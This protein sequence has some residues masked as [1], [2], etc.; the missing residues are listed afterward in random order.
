M[1]TR[2]TLCTLLVALIGLAGPGCDI[3]NQGADQEEEEQDTGDEESDEE[4]SEDEQ[5][6][7]EEAS[8]KEEGPDAGEEDAGDGKLS[9][10]DYVETSVK[11]ACVE[12][13][14]GEEDKIDLDEVEKEILG[15][16]GFDQDSY[17]DAEERFNGVDEVDTKIEKGMED[18]T[19]EKAKKYAGLIEDDSEEQEE[20]EQQEEQKE[21]PT[22]NSTGSFKGRIANQSGFDTAII[23]VTVSKDWSINGSLRGKRDGDSFRVSFDGTVNKSNRINASGSKGGDSV[24]VSG[25]VEEHGVDAKVRGSIAGDSFSASIR[26]N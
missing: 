14:L 26:A 13:E 11:L 9:L 16:Y 10:E 1:K 19:P 6:E 23:Q 17:D 8:D 20:T 15:E 25:T 3:L 7:D 12:S 5:E 21:P 24:N 2:W 18:C 4:R 22:P